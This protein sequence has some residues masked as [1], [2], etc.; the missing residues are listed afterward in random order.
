VTGWCLFGRHDRCS[1]RVGGP[2]HGG[3]ILTNGGTYSCPC[4]CHRDDSAVQLG[5]FVVCG[6]PTR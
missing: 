5:L 3:I 6:E 1:H 4:G 2:C